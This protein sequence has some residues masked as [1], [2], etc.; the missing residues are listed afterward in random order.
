M[1]YLKTYESFL[2]ESKGEAIPINEAIK[3]CED[4]R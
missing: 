4:F 2:L 1:K 3:I